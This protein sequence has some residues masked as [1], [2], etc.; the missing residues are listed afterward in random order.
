MD[1]QHVSIY[2]HLSWHLKK[3]P[4]TTFF[5]QSKMIGH[6]IVMDAIMLIMSVNLLD[7]TT[8]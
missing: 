8:T 6:E 5:V 4:I 3:V 1:E 2:R 7:S